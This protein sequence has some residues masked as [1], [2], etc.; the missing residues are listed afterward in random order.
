MDA[1]GYYCIRAAAKIRSS[2]L[3]S[4]AQCSV[5]HLTDY[6]SFKEYL[7]SVLLVQVCWVNTVML[8]LYVLSYILQI[9]LIRPKMSRKSE[10]KRQTTGR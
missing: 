7:I 2:V 10:D 1:S 6:H 8:E 3:I 9:I 5:Q 4:Q